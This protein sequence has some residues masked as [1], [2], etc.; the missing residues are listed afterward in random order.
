MR[1]DRKGE[2]EQGRVREGRKGESWIGKEREKLI[3][4]SA[5]TGRKEWGG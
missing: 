4:K 2:R 3:E 1:E 5:E